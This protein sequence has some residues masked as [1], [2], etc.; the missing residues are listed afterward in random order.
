MNNKEKQLKGQLK[1]DF[2]ELTLIVNEWDPMSLI[3]G[4]APDDEYE[5]LTISLLSQLYQEKNS[6]E[7]GEFIVGELKEEF[8]LDINNLKEEYKGRSLKRIK[9][10]CLRVEE[11]YKN[12]K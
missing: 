8:E 12:R 4:G 2:K 1:Q 11:W 10:I 9:S 6:L 3:S 5:S 7:L